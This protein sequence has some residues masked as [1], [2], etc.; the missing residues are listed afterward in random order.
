M[1]YS[2]TVTVSSVFL[3]LVLCGCATV[4]YPCAY[5]VEGQE[6]KEFK[7]LNDERALKLLALIYNVKHEAWEDG[8]ARSLALRE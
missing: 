6:F 1:R 3:C 5:K 8:I 7:D 2:L 4:R